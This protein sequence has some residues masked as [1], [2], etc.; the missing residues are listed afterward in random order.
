MV[1]L[2]LNFVA[3]VMFGKAKAETP[4]A[5]LGW[6]SAVGMLLYAYFGGY[7]QL[8]KG[9]FGAL[10]GSAWVVFNCLQKDFG[11]EAR[12]DLLVLHAWCHIPGIFALAAYERARRLYFGWWT[13]LRKS[14]EDKRGDAGPGR[15][16][17]VLYKLLPLQVTHGVNELKSLMSFEYPDGAILV[18]D[19]G[20]VSTAYR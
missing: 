4:P 9:V 3:F 1:L 18:A 16:E 19:L 20:G 2:V 15:C 11:P 14:Q 12:S 8:G 10:L 17:Q 13:L 7:M 5:D 6:Y